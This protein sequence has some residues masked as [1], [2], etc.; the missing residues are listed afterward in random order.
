VLIV[1]VLRP[2]PVLPS[3]VNR[4]VTQHIMRPTYGRALARKAENV[5]NDNK[6]IS[7]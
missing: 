2:M 1:D 3:L 6:A 5:A 7:I 4:F